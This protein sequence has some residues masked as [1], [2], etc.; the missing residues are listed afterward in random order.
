M[1]IDRLWVAGP[2]A[3]WLRNAVYD[4]KFRNNTARAPSLAGLIAEACATMDPRAD[5]VPVPMHVRRRR[6]RGYDQVAILAAAIGS[7]TGQSVNEALAK[8]LETAP[9]VGLSRS[10]RMSNLTDAFALRPHASLPDRAIL[11]DDVAT[12][13][14]T[15]AECA[16]TLRAAGV[17]SVSAVVIA[18]GL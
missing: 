13:G 8:G 3:G 10:E 4:F 5:L 15:L 7:T 6:Q 2:Y 18:H 11:I 16:R 12:T 17:S 9:Q 14:A 1:D